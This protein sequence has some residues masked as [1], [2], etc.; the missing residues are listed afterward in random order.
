MAATAEG[1]G[2]VDGEG[3]EYCAC[4][5]TTSDAKRQASARCLGVA[6][7]GKTPADGDKLRKAERKIREKLNRARHRIEVFGRL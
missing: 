4:A 6:I 1:M 7:L 5:A 3:S 2:A